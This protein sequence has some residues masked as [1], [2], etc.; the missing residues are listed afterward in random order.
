MTDQEKKRI[1]DNK[2]RRVW[3]KAMKSHRPVLSARDKLD[4]LDIEAEKEGHSISKAKK[5]RLTTLPGK[6]TK[7]K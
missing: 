1:A 7:G 5:S 3:N 6:K 2:T 4:E